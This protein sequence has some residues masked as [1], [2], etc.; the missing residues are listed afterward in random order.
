MSETLA[1]I[2]IANLVQNAIP[3]NIEEN[4][5]TKIEITIDHFSVSN[6]G[7]P[8][9]MNTKSLFKRFKR[10]SEVEESL[11]LGLSIVKRICEQSGLEVNY[12][13]FDEIHWLRIRKI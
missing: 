5:F 12:K 10:D 9:N 3:H 7:T 2:L 8:P 6:S 4:G 11:G 1:E 13:Y